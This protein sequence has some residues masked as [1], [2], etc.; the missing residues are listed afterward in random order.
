M[1]VRCVT[2][3]FLRR[4]KYISL[5]LDEWASEFRAAVSLVVRSFRAG[6]SILL[7]RDEYLKGLQWRST[8]Y[9]IVHFKFWK[10][11]DISN[12]LE[13][14]GLTIWTNR[15]GVCIH[16]CYPGIY[17]CFTHFFLPACV[18]D[19]SKKKQVNHVD[20]FD[21]IIGK[22]LHEIVICFILQKNILVCP[23]DTTRLLNFRYRNR[24]IELQLSWQQPLATLLAMQDASRIA[25]AT[26]VMPW[27]FYIKAEWQ[28]I[29]FIWI[30][31]LN[32]S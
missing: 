8:C 30:S 18:P 1:A 2:K 22:A 3:S 31:V 9:H 12:S 7:K 5:F 19:F 4:L 23:K 13:E 24:I 17:Y 29:K 11:V 21:S 16:G 32:D 15:I 27:W 26:P 14:L 28:R 25:W 6:N 10:K 20:R